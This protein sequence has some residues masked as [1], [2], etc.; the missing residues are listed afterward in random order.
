MLQP[1]IR[2]LSLRVVRDLVRTKPHALR[3]PNK[4]MIETVL[5]AHKDS[6]KEVKQETGL[7]SSKSNKN[8]LYTIVALVLKDYGQCCPVK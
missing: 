1:S 4:K 7:K 6:Q 5:I 8:I 2:L 3:G